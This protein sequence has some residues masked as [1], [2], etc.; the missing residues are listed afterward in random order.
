MRK[1]SSM[2]GMRLGQTIVAEREYAE[3]DSERMQARRKAHRK[4]RTSVV[5]VA[6]MLVVLGLMAYLGV[7]EMQKDY[8]GDGVGRAETEPVTAEIVDED[9]RE[10]ITARV[11]EYVGQLEKNLRE[12]GYTVTRVVLPTGMSRALYVDLEGR[13]GYLKVNIDRGAGVTA[14]DAVRMLKYVDE[15]G[16]TPEYIDV[17]VEGKAYYK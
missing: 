8:A 4:Q 5:I 3:S 1:K 14:E 11:R 13:T 15:S 7:K 16:L 17:R 6:L 10:Q 9:G 2:K 12:Q